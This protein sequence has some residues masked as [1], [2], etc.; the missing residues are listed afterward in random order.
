MASCINC[1]HSLLCIFR[2][3]DPSISSRQAWQ[4]PLQ[5]LHYSRRQ[6]QLSRHP[7]LPFESQLLILRIRVRLYKD[8]VHPCF[9]LCNMQP[10]T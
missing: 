7:S 9:V 4:V 3:S 1:Y 2:K 6:T 10:A 5:T 8:N